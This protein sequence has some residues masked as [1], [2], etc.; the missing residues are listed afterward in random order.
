MLETLHGILYEDVGAGVRHVAAAEQTWSESDMTKRIVRYIV[1]AA[2]ASDLLNLPWRE[3]VTKFVHNA[4]GSYSASCQEKPWFYDL[5]LSQV[6]GRASW[7]LLTSNT[8][9]PRPEYESVMEL[10]EMEYQDWLDQT[11]HR[12]AMWI[13]VEEIFSDAK[14][15]QKVFTSL[16]KTYQVAMEMAI[17]DT[18]PLGELAKLEGFMKKW[19]EDALTRSWNAVND[20]SERLLTERNSASLFR[21]L[22]AP[23]GPDHPFSCVPGVLTQ[24]I[25]RPPPNWAFIG[26]QVR[27]IFMSWQS[28]KSGGSSK[29]RRKTAGSGG[30]A[31]AEAAPLSP[32]ERTA[33]SRRRRNRREPADLG[34]EDEDAGAA[35]SAEEEELP[36][37]SEAEEPDAEEPL[38]EDELLAEPPAA[39]DDDEEEQPEDADDEQGH[40]QCTSQEDCLGSPSDGLIRHIL[41]GNRGDCYCNTCWESFRQQNPL[42]EG[43]PEVV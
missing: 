39:V 31:I 11:L 42:L 34:D 3:A 23:F 18:R 35:L 7:E 12:K 43:Q 16:Q 25:G 21:K 6:F 27:S 40:P 20:E 19:M 36:A 41:H 28:Q 10:A 1:K 9:R 2:S 17:Q 15:R 14:V 26:Q 33:A 22:M 37:A 29:K 5:D 30:E 4:M 38:P 32:I 8:I 13:A 24:S